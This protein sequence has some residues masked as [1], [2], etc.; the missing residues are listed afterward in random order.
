MLYLLETDKAGKIANG[1][2][3]M[4]LVKLLIEK[5]LESGDSHKSEFDTLNEMIS[6]VCPFITSDY[7]TY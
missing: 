5:V 6:D 4:Y 3:K 2:Y 7:Y 1:E